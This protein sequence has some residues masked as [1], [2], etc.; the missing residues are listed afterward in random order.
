MADI[1]I[2]GCGYV[3][4]E[5]TRRL[6][7]AGHRVYAMRRSS[8]PVP[9]EAIRIIGDATD[10]NLAQLLPH[11]I[12]YLFYTAA[13]GGF[14]E[15]RYR[16]AY[17]D[18]PRNLMG[19]LQSSGRIPRRLFFT[20]STGVYA[21]SAGE[22]VNEESLAAPVHFS[23]TAI[24]EGEDIFWCSGFPATILRLAGIYGP[25][26]DRLIQQVRDGLA[27]IGPTPVISNLIHRDDCAG[28]LHH[29]MELA[30]PERLYVG[31]DC[32]PVERGAL[33]RWIAHQV[34]AAE[35]ATSDVVEPSVRAQRSNKRCD[36]SL[37][38]ESGYRFKFPTF[39]EGYGAL[40]GN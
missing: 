3:G 35:P 12:D 1:L 31:V 32:E 33:L 11:T 7:M 34:G 6:T 10:P 9:E 16:Q 27:I 30:S 23:G 22:V 5:L 13:A 21:Q 29:L 8:R 4:S 20:S 28:A 40:I 2:V 39:R 26:R 24:R 18:G 37:L 15:E 25:G 17:V 38:R 14:S 19:A 36:S